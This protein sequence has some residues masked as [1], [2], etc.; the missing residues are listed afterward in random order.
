[1]AVAIICAWYRVY[2]AGM[3]VYN[4]CTLFSTLSVTCRV[5]QFHKIEYS[6]SQF[7]VI[8][9]MII[10]MLTYFLN[11]DE[12]FLSFHQDLWK[13]QD[14]KN[15]PRPGFIFNNRFFGKIEGD[16]RRLYSHSGSSMS[17]EKLIFSVFPDS[18]AWRG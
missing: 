7:R 18:N 17:M 4:C 11:S 3:K 16:H 14:V 8:V 9:I 6:V 10:W 12:S 2:G 15:I 1:M 13:N 5:N